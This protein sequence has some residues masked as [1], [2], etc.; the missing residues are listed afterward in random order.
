[1]LIMI[2]WKWVNNCNILIHRATEEIISEDQL[3]FDENP[4]YNEKA[5]PSHTDNPSPDENR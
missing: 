1:M 2:Y 5:G 4:S 3:Y